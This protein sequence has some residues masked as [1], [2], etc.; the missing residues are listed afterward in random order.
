MNISYYEHNKFN[1]VGKY[2]NFIRCTFSFI[3]FL[4]CFIFVSFIFQLLDQY[5][6]K[7]SIQY[8]LL[9]TM[10]LI[11]L[12][13][14]LRKLRLIAPLS[15]LANIAL[16]TGVTT[17]MYYSCSGLVENNDRR[18]SYSKWSDLPMMF[19]IIM[20]SFE[21]IGLVSVLLR[22]LLFFSEIE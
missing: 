7:L 13:A 14:C 3:C 10:P 5:E 20:F 22:F 1:T 17:I 9:L 4:N 2:I 11:L 15:T 21:G 8:V 18:Y 19:G 6:H 12:C 16:I